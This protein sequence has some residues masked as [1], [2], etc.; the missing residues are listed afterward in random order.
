MDGAPA[1][2]DPRDAEIAALKEEAGQLKD[3]L[4][5]TLAEMENVRKRAEREKAEATL[6]AAT[7]FARDILS[8]SDNMS[9]ALELAHA[10]A[11]K[12]APEAVKNLIGGR[13]SHQSRTAQ[14]LR[15]PRHQAHRPQGREI[16]SP[17]STR[18]CS[19][20]RS[21]DHPPGT[22]IEVMRAGFSIG[23]RLL[24]PALVGV[25]KAP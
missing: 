4:L 2:A 23:D 15:A 16:R 22:I 12:D 8:V 3:R 9:K 1:G 20:F 18:R 25:A 19:R 6:Y 13:R 10:D 11:I 14:C 21:K 17:I 24:R 7:N 5:R